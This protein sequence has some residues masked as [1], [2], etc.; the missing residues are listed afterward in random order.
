[1][2]INVTDYFTNDLEPSNYSGS[3]MEKGENAAKI[4]WQAAIDESESLI[5][6]KTPEQI[7]ALKTDMVNAGMDEEEINQMSDIESN[8]LFLQLI[9]GD[10]REDNEYLEQSPIDWEG[11]EKDDKTIGRLGLGTDN[12]IYYYLGS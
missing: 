3:I 11:Y 12:E 7:Q 2:E 1:M 10:V 8:A 4:T 6:L 5:L 9:S